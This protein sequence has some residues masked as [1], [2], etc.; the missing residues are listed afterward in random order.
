MKKFLFT[1]AT[2]FAAAL[3]ANASAPQLA[4]SDTE[5]TLGA[6]ESQEI[7]IQL[8]QGLDDIMRGCQFQFVMYNPAGER[9]PDA[10]I[11]QKKYSKNK[12]WFGAETISTAGDEG[13]EGNA[14]G[15]SNPFP[16][17][18]RFLCSNASC[19]EFWYPESQYLEWEYEPHT[20]PLNVIAFTVKVNVDNWADQYAILRLECNPKSMEDEGEDEYPLKAAMIGQTFVIEDGAME[21]K[22]NNADYQ[23]STT[24]PLEGTVTIG[25]NDGYNVPIE[26]DV[27]GTYDLVVTVAKDGGEAVE[28]P[29]E[30]GMIVLGETPD[31]GTYVIN[32]TAT[33][34][35]DYEGTVSAQEATVVIDQLKKDNP[36]I[37][38]E[39]GADGT[40]NIVIENAT[41]YEVKVDG[42]LYDGL[43]VAPIYDATQE[44]VVEAWN[45]E[46]GYIAG[47][48]TN[49]TT[50]APKA[51]APAVNPTITFV[52]GETGVTINVE[53][54]TSYEVIVD[55]VNM[56]EINF[57]EKTWEEQN[58]VVNAVN[59][60]AHQ[61]KGE[62]T[63]SYTLA[64]R[65]NMNLTGPITIG[66]VEEDG[67][68][69]VSYEGNEAGVTLTAT[70]DGEPA[71]IENG[72]IQLPTYGDY[73]IEVTASATHYNDLVKSENRSWVEPG[74]AE[75]PVITFTPGE[76]GVTI[77]VDPATSWEVIV[78][79]TNMGQINFVEKTWAE[80][81]IV[82]NAT[83]E[84]TGM[85]PAYAS[86]EY[87]LAAKDDMTFAG[88]IIFGAVEEGG[89]VFVQYTGEEDITL[90]TVTITGVREVQTIEGKAGYV[91]LP[92]YGK[93][94]LAAAVEG[95]HYVTLTEEAVR[96]WLEPETTTTAPEI[97]TAVDEENHQ[98]VVTATGANPDDEVTLHVIVYPNDPTQEPQEIVLT[99][100]GSVSI[101]V[102]QTEEVQYISYWASAQNPADDNPGINNGAQYVEVPAYIP[103]VVDEVTATP[104]IRGEEFLWH[105]E[106]E[107]LNNTAY[108]IT[109]TCEDADA[110]IMYR[111]NGGEWTP[112]TGKFIIHGQDEE[113]FTIE[114]TAIAPGKIVSNTAV[115]TFTMY[116]IPTSIDE[117]MNAENVANVR[118]FNVAGQEMQEANGMT[119]VVVTYTD[120]RTISTK[121]MK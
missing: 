21:L 82:V 33:G 87:T 112:Y 92:G 120:G 49:N 57:V 121:I 17:K 74:T 81:H 93:W 110:A 105:S 53:D 8:L 106:S 97:T 18:Y 116:A 41:R 71:T 40:V 10:V 64:A 70:V 15:T 25:A 101:P 22:I 52:P 111:I 13:N 114:S 86:D 66:A 29:V 6:G 69:Y 11:L 84:V 75:V 89:R 27:N 42:E 117:I 58:I 3:V 98:F 7:H 113:V 91:Q 37:N 48:A 109:I 72:Y 94:N 24:T 102:D 35:G 63:D 115:E 85:N 90:F 60:P 65:D 100:T 30:N 54:Y 80:Q 32:A 19:N 103:P 61:E 73:T 2:L 56:G 4:L 12:Q 79:G 28:V 107:G 59:E 55:G 62:A 119:I 78:D 96:E 1:L 36:T 5:I 45:E 50:V 77:T 44:V 68:V 39:V 88:D 26:V 9:I 43:S 76:T 95:E 23:G 47:Y 38:F 16:A 14:V 83:N 34:N 20:Y 104:N 67:K 51:Y 46:T 99:G 108:W 31:Y 118:F